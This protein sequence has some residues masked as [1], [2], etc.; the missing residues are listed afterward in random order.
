MNMYRVVPQTKRLNSYS[1]ILVNCNLYYSLSLYHDNVPYT[2]F[3]P[4]PSR[5]I[6]N[7]G[8]MPFGLGT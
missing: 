6:S 2:V 3:Q 8:H 5:D 7:K 1:N 4:L